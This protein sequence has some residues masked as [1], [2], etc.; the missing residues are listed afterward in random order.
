MCLRIL[1]LLLCMIGSAARAQSVNVTPIRP[2]IVGGVGFKSG[3]WYTSVG[4]TNAAGGTTATGSEFC[5]PFILQGDP[6]NP[7]FTTD[8]VVLDITTLAV[9]G[10]VQYGFRAPG[11]GT[12]SGFPGTLLGN[13]ASQSTTTAQVVS[14]AWT[15]N[16]SVLTG[17]GYWIC[18]QVDNST[19]ILQG[20]TTAGSAQIPY[21]GSSTAAA[22]ITTPQSDVTA[23][24]TFGTWTADGS[25]LSWAP[26]AANRSVWGALHVNSIP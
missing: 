6:N 16:F 4:Q 12:N 13:T 8:Q 23:T 11:T 7:S 10:N 2:S 26:A 17:R 19:V 9:S 14:V 24:E 15:A 25:S 20:V 21:I 3:N 1:C 18:R 22:T 5:S